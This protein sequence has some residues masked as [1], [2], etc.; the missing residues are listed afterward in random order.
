MKIFRQCLKHD[1]RKL[2]RKDILISILMFMGLF[3]FSHSVIA[4]D[5]LKNIK[6]KNAEAN[7]ECLKCHGHKFYTYYNDWTDKNVIKRMNPFYVIDSALFYTQNHCTFKCTDCHDEDYSKFPHNGQLQ[8]EEM[9]TCLD[10]HEG[11]EKT[12][13]YHFENIYKEYK[14]SIHCK[15]FGSSFSCWLCHNPHKYKVTARKNDDISK[16]IIYDN[17]ICLNC[18][19]NVVNYSVLSDSAPKNMVAAHD[20]LPNQR[21]HF[22]HVRCL[23]CH[24]KVQHG[25]M[26]DHDIL[27]KKDAVKKCVECHSKNTFLMATLYKFQSKNRRKQLGFLNATILNNSYV[28]GANRN[29]FLNKVSLIIFGLVIVIIII[30]GILRIIKK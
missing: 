29:P 14:A 27:P 24:A 7:H 3:V 19:S 13:K 8:M 17:E 9:P 23:D 22:Q 12:A 4:Q 21:L 25:T 10:C 20:W 5:T 1:N 16:V 2:F 6:F 26:V 15:Q 18:H 30:H 28:M 11:D